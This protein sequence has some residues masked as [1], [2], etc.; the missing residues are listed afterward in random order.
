MP[1]P[2][3]EK[4]Y[5][6]VK[7]EAKKKFDVWPSIYASAWVAREYQ[8][9]GGKYEGKKPKK[10]GLNRWFEEE[11]LDVCKLPKKVPCGRP[12]VKDMK[13][14]KKDYPYC[15]PNKRVTKDTPKTISEF[16]KKELEKR[17]E[18]KKKN[19]EKKIA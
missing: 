13:N 9:R 12:N 19:P 10:S 6:K 11:W 2:L 14:W 4:L 3:N 8:N 15:R 16:T 18:K 17:C 1:T 5:E 7:K